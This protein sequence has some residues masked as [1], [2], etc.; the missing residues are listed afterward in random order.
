MKIARKNPRSANLA[1][2][3]RGDT[4]SRNLYQNLA[5]M[6][7]TKIVRFDWSAQSVSHEFKRQEVGIKMGTF[8]KQ[9]D[10]SPTFEKHEDHSPPPFG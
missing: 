3:N 2:T 6:Q 8:D 10:H 7:V 4:R 9:E 1:K 5:P